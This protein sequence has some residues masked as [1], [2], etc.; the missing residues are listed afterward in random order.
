MKVEKGQVLNPKGRGN[1]PNKT[2]KKARELLTDFMDES[3]ED[4]KAAWNRLEDAD[5][6][7]TWSTLAKY[8][9]PT[10]TSVKVE[11]SNGDDVLKKIL[12]NQK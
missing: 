7:K 9:M 10:L 5:K 2:T 11:D 6:V 12:D 3:F 4:V 8:V 1:V